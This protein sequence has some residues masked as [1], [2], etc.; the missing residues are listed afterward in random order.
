VKSKH[1]FVP[2]LDVSEVLPFA[3][4][5]SKN[6][7]Q[8]M[9]EQEIAH[10]QLLKFVDQLEKAF[11]QQCYYVGMDV[12]GEKSYER[13]LLEKGGFLEVMMESPVALN[14]HFCKQTQAKDFLKALKTALSKTLKDNPL[15]SMFINSIE[16]QCEEDQ[17]L[18]VSSWNKMKDIRKK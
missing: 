12:I 3:I 8:S 14:A 9:Q 5:R 1:F 17:S 13:F 18:N 11:K 15:A 7:A 6:L 16:V 2:A 10:E 4:K